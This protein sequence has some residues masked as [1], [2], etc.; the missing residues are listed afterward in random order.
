MSAAL[1]SV[2]SAWD[3]V[4][5]CFRQIRMLPDPVAN[6]GDFELTIKITA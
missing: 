6:S 2:T 1:T 3:G 4:W 5:E